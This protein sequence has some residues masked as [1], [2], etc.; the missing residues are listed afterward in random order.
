MFVWYHSRLHFSNYINVEA[1]AIEKDILKWY[2]IHFK[3]VLCHLFIH[4]VLW[5][6]QTN[7]I[8][9]HYIVS[10]YD[11]GY[12]FA[13]Q[14]LYPLSCLLE[15][16]RINK[17]HILVIYFIYSLRNVYI[18]MT[19]FDHDHIY[20]LFA[21]SVA[22][23][24]SKTHFSQLHI[25][26]IFKYFWEFHIWVFPFL[27]LHLQLLPCPSPFTLKAIISSLMLLLIHVQIACI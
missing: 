21:L 18:Y 20:T 13:W 1:K 26:F 8:D 22:Q 15:T 5:I 9:V 10:G 14:T 24:S 23:I 12:T 6:G 19:Q 11:L 4:Y 25:L 16:K 7:I 2:C 27:L 17:K 3:L